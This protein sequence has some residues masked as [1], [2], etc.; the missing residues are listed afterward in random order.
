MKELFSSKL[1]RHVLL[2]KSKYRLNFLNCI[3]CVVRKFG[4]FWP[5]TGN[6]NKHGNSLA[7]FNLSTFFQLGYTI[8][9]LRG[10]VRAN[11]AEID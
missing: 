7:I 1:I 11:Q 2:I 8:N 5:Y 9:V 6:P 3:G 10:C 4:E